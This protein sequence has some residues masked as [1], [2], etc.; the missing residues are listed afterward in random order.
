[1]DQPYGGTV[2][3]KSGNPAL[4]YRDENSR[5]D[6]VCVFTLLNRAPTFNRT[7]NPANAGFLKINL[8]QHGSIILSRLCS[9]LSHLTRSS[10]GYF[11]TPLRVGRTTLTSV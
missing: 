2:C 10:R 4:S 9:N 1:M 11:F 6:R 5:Q 7:L 8:N 3:V